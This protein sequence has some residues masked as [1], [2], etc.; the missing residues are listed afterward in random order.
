MKKI[1]S[2]FSLVLVGLI[3][4]SSTN[5]YAQKKM[6]KEPVMWAAEN[7]KWEEM[8]D[9]PP[10]VMT[11]TLWG[12]ITKGAYGALVKFPANTKHPL[13]THSGDI[14]TVVLSGTFTYAPEGGEEKSYGAGSYLLLP[15]GSKHISG[16]GP[17]GCTFFM[18]QPSKFD[19]K[20]VEMK[21]DE[22][23]K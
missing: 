1:L 14:K 22:M 4:I 3:F 19:M 17:D 23:K 7:I 10:G 15:G 13:H 16:S 5:V 20:M 12:D 18:E 11:A 9:G 2:F 6:K 21:K 8:K